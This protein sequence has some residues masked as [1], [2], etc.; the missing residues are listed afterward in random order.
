MSK[1][2]YTILSYTRLTWHFFFIM[3]NTKQCTIKIIICCPLNYRRTMIDI[4]YINITKL[5]DIYIYIY[6]LLNKTCLSKQET[7]RE[8]VR[9]IFFYF[10]KINLPRRKRHKE[11]SSF[12][13]CVRI[14][15]RFSLLLT[16][17]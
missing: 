13:N 15:I 4:S 1:S 6:I 5:R 2:S 8:N 9:Y 10:R 11:L 17:K 14:V 3:Y 16:Y 12:L 7:S